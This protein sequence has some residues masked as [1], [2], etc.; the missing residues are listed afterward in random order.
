MFKT[1]NIITFCA[2]FMTIKKLKHAN[3]T[4]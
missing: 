3:E 4:V 1:R 2:E